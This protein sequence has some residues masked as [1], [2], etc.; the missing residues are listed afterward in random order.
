MSWQRVFQILLMAEVI[1]LS[2][3]I[4]RLFAAAIIG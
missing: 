4:E 1:A 3:K 2:Q